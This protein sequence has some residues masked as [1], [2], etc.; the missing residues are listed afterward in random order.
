MDG[1]KL[2]ARLLSKSKRKRNAEK[3]IQLIEELD[4]LNHK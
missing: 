1:G 2:E 4:P 3:K